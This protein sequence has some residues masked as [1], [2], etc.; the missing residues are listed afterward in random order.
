MER[1]VKSIGR[2]P[3]ICPRST[4]ETCLISRLFIRKMA[5]YYK[6]FA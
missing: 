4:K 5:L 2:Q 3:M 6:L 1:G